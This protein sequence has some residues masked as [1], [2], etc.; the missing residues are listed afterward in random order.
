MKH[1]FLSFF[2]PFMAGISTIIGYLPTY[3]SS[4]YRDRIIGFSL[5]FSAGVM[6][7]ISFLSLIP[8]A[9]SYLSYQRYS[10]L[11]IF[12]FCI[13][14]ILLSYWIDS[15]LSKRFHGTKLYQVGIVSVVVLMIHNLPEGITTFL[16]TTS[17][18]KLGFSLSLAIAI[19]NIPEGITIAI[20][21]YYATG[22]RWKAFLYT[23]ISGFSEFVGALI[24]Y[25][26]LSSYLNPRFLGIILSMTAGIMIHISVTELIPNSFDYGN[27]KEGLTGFIIGIGI[28]LICIYIFQ[29]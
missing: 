8:E 28:M 20:P 21:I 26:F 24:A 12:L 4:K 6:L 5:M 14:G 10:T 7:V 2:I 16:T 13:L 11:L 18:L 23:A 1:L 27:L 19:H 22:N 25:F 29:L 15:I 9:R 3:L 17:N